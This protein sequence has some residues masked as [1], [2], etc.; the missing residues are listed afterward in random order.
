[1]HFLSKMQRF[2]PS[3]FRVSV[4]AFV[5]MTAA[6]G[7]PTT[8]AGQTVN[9]TP[10]AF[11]VSG[12]VFENQA[13]IKQA[14]SDAWVDLWGLA[15]STGGNCTTR[16]SMLRG[17]NMFSDASGRYVASGLPAGSAV[18]IQ[19]GKAGYVAPCATT[20]SGQD[21]HADLELVP[22]TSFDTANPLPLTTNRPV[23]SGMV[24]ETT[25][26]GPKGV[27][28]AFLSVET[29]PDLVVATTMTDLTG[30]FTMCSVAVSYVYAGKSGYAPY[31]QQASL[32]N[33]MAIELK[34]Q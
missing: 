23:L 26:D 31:Y 27:A 33:G 2:S 28:G 5:M 7:A 24:F 32:S 22:M 12:M 25:S 34:R 16:Y 29:L 4:A 17:S 3:C 18:N 30:H 21:D 9:Q 20:A 1:M 19:V 13:G 10:P 14:V 8:P 6:C 15:C 11:T